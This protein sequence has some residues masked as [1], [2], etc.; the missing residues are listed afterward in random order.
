MFL[1]KS[2]SKSGIYQLYFKDS[3][4]G[5]RRNVSTHTRMKSDA[6]EFLRP[7]EEEKTRKPLSMTLSQFTA[8][9]P[10]YAERTEPTIYIRRSQGKQD[11]HRRYPISSNKLPSC[12]RLAFAVPPEVFFEIPP[13]KIKKYLHLFFSLCIYT[14]ILQQIGYIDRLTR[15]LVN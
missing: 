4:T 8:D 7:F 14:L 3:I 2:T 13:K 1:S 5:K 6:I 10:S 9:F 11:L 15:T 12:R